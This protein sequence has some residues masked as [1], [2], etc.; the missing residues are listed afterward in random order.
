[1]TS[2]S[3]TRFSNSSLLAFFISIGI[4]RFDCCKLLSSLNF[5]EDDCE[6]FA[7]SVS[8]LPPRA[9]GLAGDS[10][11]RVPRFLIRSNARLP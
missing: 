2:Y 3:S 8:V 5:S 11:V 10:L 4:I 1:M 6:A 9:S 7:S